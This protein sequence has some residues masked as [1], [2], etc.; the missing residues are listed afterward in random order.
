MEAI[1]FGTDGIRGRVGTW[2]MDPIGAMQIGQGVGAYLRHK[3]ESPRVLIGRDTRL[4]GD[5]L[6]AALASGLMSQGVTVV[7]VG[8]ITTAGAAYLTS[9]YGMEAG[10][11]ISASHNPW[12]ENGIKLIGPAGLK[13]SDDEEEIIEERIAQAIRGEL[14]SSPFGRLE[15]H[16]EW[17]EAYIQHLIEPFDSLAFAGLRVALDCSNGAASHI[18]PACF[19]RL[20]CRTIVMHAAPDGV[21]INQ[22]CG[23]EVV[24]AGQSDLP[25]VAR[26]ASVQLAVAFDGD[27]DR[28]ILVDEA[29]N[30]IDGDH[31]LYIIGT[32]LKGKGALRGNAVVTT[33]MANSGLD[34][35][36]AR[37]GIN[38]VRTRVG[39]RY[40]MQEMLEKGYILGGE[41]SGHIVI[42][43][44]THT[45]G[46]GIYTAL[47]LASVLVENG[48]TTLQE[49]AAPVTKLPQVI[50]SARVESK[51]PL[52]TLESFLR[53]RDTVLQELGDE[54]TVNVR[55]SGTEPLV[56][57]MVEGTTAQSL[58]DVARQAVRLCRAVQKAVGGGDEDID[59]KD[60]TT[61]ASLDLPTTGI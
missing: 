12:T 50:A 1:E 30:L 51:P 14:E 2:P 59:I 45:T 32:Y 8:V 34:R 9:R 27:A 55:Y 41:Q 60:C 42:Y 22:G 36:L 49:L 29:G 40:V 57:V 13:L 53:E 16:P 7:D 46:D 52:D 23:S 35:A 48:P 21:N 39:D 54:A 37:H 6:M 28:A 17:Q 4:S 31:I 11:V 3:T 18:A 47:F 43:D 61:G 56:R 20:G 44:E 10:I 33:Q 5:A 24:R 58:E 19:A 15:Q 38:T 25:H 26:A